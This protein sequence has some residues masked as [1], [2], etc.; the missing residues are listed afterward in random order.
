MGGMG[1]FVVIGERGGEA[2]VER[3]GIH[4]KAKDPIM[5]RYYLSLTLPPVQD[6]MDLTP[7]LPVEWQRQMPRFYWINRYNSRCGCLL[8]ESCVEPHFCNQ[9]LWIEKPCHTW[10]RY[11]GPAV[12]VAIR[13]A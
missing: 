2:Y 5:V 12:D 1:D 9:K 10:S 7:D 13:D 6:T 4:V 11:R 8:D 3:V